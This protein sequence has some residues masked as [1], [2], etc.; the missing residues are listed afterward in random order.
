MN[1]DWRRQLD[2][3]QSHFGSLHALAAEL[4]VGERTVQRWRKKSAP[5]PRKEQIRDLYER[6]RLLESTTA[7]KRRTAAE[8]RTQ[9]EVRTADEARTQTEGRTQTEVRTADEVG[10]ELGDPFYGS[11]TDV[12]D[13]C[14]IPLPNRVVELVSWLS[15]PL[16][17]PI[18][19]VARYAPTAGWIIARSRGQQANIAAFKQYCDSLKAAHR[20]PTAKEQEQIT[21]LAVYLT[22]CWELEIHEDAEYGCHARITKPNEEAVEAKRLY[23]FGSGETL[24]LYTPSDRRRLLRRTSRVYRGQLSKYAE[25]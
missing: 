11:W 14:L 25:L 20:R 10:P 12:I 8:V 24:R 21:D 1:D 18:P 23:V 3:L 9:T 16:A 17:D 4:K 7:A 22:D 13:R 5:G 15:S 2:W 19:C 6:E